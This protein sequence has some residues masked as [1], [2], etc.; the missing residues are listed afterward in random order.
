MRLHP[1]IIVPAVLAAIAVAVVACGG[2]PPFAGRTPE[3]TLSTEPTLVI[4]EDGTPEGELDRVVAALALPGGEIAVVDAGHRHIRVFSEAGAH[5][6]TLG[7]RGSGPGEFSRISWA[8]LHGDTLLVYDDGARRATLLGLDGGVF[9]TVVP[10]VTDEIVAVEPTARLPGGS[11]LVSIATAA[12]PPVGA[13]GAFRD[14]LRFGVLPP[15]GIGSL[16]TLRAMPTPLIVVVPG[17]NGLVPG[18]FAVWPVAFVLD[19]RIGF[20]DADAATITW[21]T[22]AG[23]TPHR[24]ELPMPR[25]PLSEV[26]VE[27]LRAEALGGITNER[28]R[29]VVEARFAREAVPA[30]LPA[31]R[32]LL[33]DA[34]DAVWLEEWRFEESAPASYAV[35]DVDG[36]WLA[37]VAMPPGFTPTTIGP[38]WV[39]GIHRDADGVQRVMRYGLER[40]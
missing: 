17:L 7:R 29:P 40:R 8:A 2:D 33:P 5:L 15:A 30:E 39:L 28:T 6:R 31:F 34:D 11:W 38:D 10:R 25:R 16:Q 18:R 9:E 12:N 35:I 14:S 4:G 37:T 22:G 27:R 19:S 32:A 24:I 26:E 3:W 21:F 20:A 1:R 23:A 36:K 13:T